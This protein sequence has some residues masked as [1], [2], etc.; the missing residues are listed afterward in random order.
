MAQTTKEWVL[1][2][3]E[4]KKEWIDFYYNNVRSQDEINELG[5]LLFQHI[6]NDL[7]DEERFHPALLESITEEDCIAYMHYLA[8]ETPYIGYAR[9]HGLI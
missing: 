4:T 8:V 5:R 7:P 6:F 9:E 3:T 1:N 2:Y